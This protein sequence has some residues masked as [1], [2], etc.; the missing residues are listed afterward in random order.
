[1][2]LHLLFFTA[3]PPRGDR[4]E[5]K[6]R[7]YKN[8]KIEIVNLLPFPVVMSKKSPYVLRITRTAVF[9]KSPLVP[10]LVLPISISSSK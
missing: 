6:A 10:D 9:I 7:I 8:K 4:M 2:K 3:V 5:P 1:L